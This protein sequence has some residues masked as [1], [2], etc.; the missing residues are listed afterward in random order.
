VSLHSELIELTYCYGTR[1]RIQILSPTS[2]P[3]HRTHARETRD[4]TDAAL[5]K[6]NTIPAIERDRQITVSGT[7]HCGH[8]LFIYDLSTM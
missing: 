8:V 4:A 7:S 1:E 2:H 3:T 6:E 5:K